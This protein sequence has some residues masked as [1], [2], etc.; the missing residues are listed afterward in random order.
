MFNEESNYFE[1]NASD[2][3]DFRSTIFSTISVWAWTEKKH[4][5]MRAM[6]KKLNVF[7]LQQPICYTLE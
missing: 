6:K 1:E 7:T 2:N 3:K 5:V 4:V